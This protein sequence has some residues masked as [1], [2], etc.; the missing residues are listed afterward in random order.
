MNEVL[1]KKRVF[2]ASN[3]ANEVSILDR[4]KQAFLWIQFYNE[5]LLFFVNEKLK[6]RSSTDSWSGIS[7]NLRDDEITIMTA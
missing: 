6:Q 7:P 4:E 3:Y 5:K 1:E 2:F